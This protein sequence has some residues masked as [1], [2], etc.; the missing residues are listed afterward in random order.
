MPPE[1]VTHGATFEEL[2][3]TSLDALALI[4]ELEEE[5]DISMPNEEAMG[6]RDVRQAIETVRR[7]LSPEAAESSP[8]PS[9]ESSGATGA[10]GAGGE[11]T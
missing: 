6:L 9:P 10:G 4:Y 7:L 11:R 3:M 2:G 1:Q 8:A 5:F